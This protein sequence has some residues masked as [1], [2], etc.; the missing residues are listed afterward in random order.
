MTW[1]KLVFYITWLCDH[2]DPGQGIADQVGAYG[3]TPPGRGLLEPV[4]WAMMGEPVAQ[5]REKHELIIRRAV[6]DCFEMCLGALNE[7]TQ[8]RLPVSNKPMPNEQGVRTVSFVTF[9]SMQMPIQPMPNENPHP[10]RRL[11]FQCSLGL[12][13]VTP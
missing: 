13:G 11:S 7:G 2:P 4:R 9:I 12:G 10:D 3:N 5:R 6:I 1:E 8:V